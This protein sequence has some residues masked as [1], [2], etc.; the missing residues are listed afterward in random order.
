MSKRVDA[1]QMEV[2]RA[3]MQTQHVRDEALD[4]ERQL[5]DTHMALHGEHAA[6]ARAEGLANESQ[7]EVRAIRNQ[8]QHRVVNMELSAAEVQRCRSELA[9]KCRLSRLAE[10]ERLLA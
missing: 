9:F 6:K 10:R 1:L 8:M 2:E 3:R 4:F 5:E 7:R